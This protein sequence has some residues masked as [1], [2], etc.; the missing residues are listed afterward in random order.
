MRTISVALA[1]AL[2]LSLP[3]VAQEERA[4]FYF[5]QTIRREAVDTS[6]LHTET[7]A[8]ANDF[9]ANPLAAKRDS[10]DDQE[11]WSEFLNSLVRHHPSHSNSRH[12]N[13]NNNNNINNNNEA[14]D[15]DETT[16]D[17]TLAPTIIA[18]TAAP[19]DEDAGDLDSSM[20]TQS[21][22]VVGPNGIVGGQKPAASSSPPILVP[23][24]RPI[25]P[26]PAAPSGAP[27]PTPQPGGSGSS[28]SGNSDDDSDSN[29]NSNGGSSSGSGGLL[30]PIDSLL[31]PLVPA[32]S[33]IVPDVPSVV[34]SGLGPIV[35]PVKSI[36]TPIV[37]PVVSPVNSILTPILSPVASPVN[38][39]LTPILSPVVSPV[40]SILTPI[41]PGTLIIPFGGGP[42]I[43]V[44]SAT[45]SAVT[46]T[47]RPGPDS[48][49]DGIGS[50]WLDPP[51]PGDAGPDHPPLSGGPDWF[52]HLLGGEPCQLD[53]ILSGLGDYADLANRHIIDPSIGSSDVSAVFGSQLLL[54]NQVI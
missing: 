51:T 49:A 34:N 10:R 15:D 32:P 22:I 31:P 4:R 9:S 52:G 47:D 27:A 17:P 50:Q 3:A 18:P 28:D 6:E 7:D 23:N 8:L 35:T 13:N 30:D 16:E 37:T 26:N 21:A 20:P 38:S 19:T 45:Y 40:N 48:P 33:R 39:I 42:N 11:A 29:G 36:L 41:L 46:R 43:A 54:A 24:P 44:D 5:P 14:A 25:Q 2:S 53:R 12:N 1:A